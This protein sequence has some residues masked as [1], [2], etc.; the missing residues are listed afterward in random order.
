VLPD[1][2]A[3]N[4]TEIKGWPWNNETDPSIYVK[5]IKWPSI[6]I[7][8]PSFN[9]GI[10]IEETIRSVLLQ[11]YPLLE[12]IVI[13][14]G[15]SDDSVDVIKKY[16]TYITHW[17]SEPDKGQSHAINKGFNLAT[18]EIINWLNSDD[19]LEKDALYHLALAFL[20]NPSEVF[21]YGQFVEFN[22]HGQLPY[23]PLPSDDLPRRYYYDFPY[24]QPS[25]FF[26]KKI[27]DEIG[28][29]DE[30]F[31]FSMDLDLYVRIACK[32]SILKIDNVLSRFRWHAKSKST[33]LSDIASEERHM[34]FYSLYKS[35]GFMDCIQLLDRIGLKPKN[36]LYYNPERK[37]IFE[38]KYSIFLGFLTDKINASYIRKNYPFVR[39]CV[40]FILMKQPMFVFRKTLLRKTIALCLPNFIL[41]HIQ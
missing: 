23:K 21:I 12:L 14:G 15:S 28:P 24:A 22:E 27:L 2:I 34:I 4:K 31:Q 1:L 30:D 9:Q 29:I 37:E 20:K 16:E 8:V 17:V 11:N 7:V 10:F 40:K 33:N 38:Y 3:L 5:E 39:Q 13:D 35:A 32:H 25:A 6:S 19:L 18:G 26:K 41:R 36:Q